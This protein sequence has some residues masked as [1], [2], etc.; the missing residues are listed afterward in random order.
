[1]NTILWVCQG[2]L[3]LAFLYSGIN[4]LI[5]S[6]QQLI[7]KGQTGVVNLPV[8]VIRFIGISEVLGATGIIVPW[9][10]NIWPVLT[11][12]TAVCFAVIM[13]LA[14]QIHYKLHEPKNV[15]TNIFLLVLAAFVA[16]GRWGN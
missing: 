16:Y 8:A 13:V 15:A 14:V 6:E 3:S 5:F 1:M 4:K 7:A 11:P 9:L 2:I 10:T 12:V